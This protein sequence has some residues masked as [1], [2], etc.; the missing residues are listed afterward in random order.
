ME[1]LRRGNVLRRRNNILLWITLRYCPVTAVMSRIRIVLLSRDIF[2]A[3]VR[4]YVASAVRP[5]TTTLR[6]DGAVPRN[7]Q[8]E[9]RVE[10]DIFYC[11]MSLYCV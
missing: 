6:R 9:N 5:I 8:N 11:T 1:L 4:V 2:G 10:N 7:V 3:V